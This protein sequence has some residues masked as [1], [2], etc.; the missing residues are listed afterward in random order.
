MLFLNPPQVLLLQSS[1]Q[2]MMLGSLRWKTSAWHPSP[3]SLLC[4]NWV[5]T[6]MSPTVIIH[7]SCDS[8]G[9]LG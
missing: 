5:R 2:R 7:L 3:H 8:L 1:V 9:A 6:G 4:Q